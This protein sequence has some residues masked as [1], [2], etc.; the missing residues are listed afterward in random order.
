MAEEA[1]HGITGEVVSAIA[2]HT[3]GAPEPLLTSFLVGIGN[4]IGPGPHALVGATRHGLKLFKV[5]VGRSSKSRK[6]TGW[7]HLLELFR[8]VDPEWTDAHITSGLSSGEGLIWAVRDPLT[9]RV[10][11]K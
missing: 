2:P 7:D 9:R 5:D 6:G 4:L 8:R 1:F 10:P 11:K 3:E